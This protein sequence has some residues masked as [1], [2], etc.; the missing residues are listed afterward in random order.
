M[1]TWRQ[2]PGLLVWAVGAGALLAL[3][4]KVDLANLAMLLVMS[5]ALATLWLPA[6]LAAAAGTLAV[7]AFNW[8]FVPPRGSLMV[9]LRQHALLLLSMLLVNLLVVALMQRLRQQAEQAA[10]AG[11]RESRLRAWSDTLRDADEPLEQSATLLAELEALAGTPVALIALDHR[12]ATVPPARLT[13]GQPDADQ[14]AGLALCLGEGH[15]LGPGSGRF[16]AL[17]D[18]YL[19]LRGRGRTLGAVVLCGLGL[20]ATASDLHTQAQTLCDLFGQALQRTQDRAEARRAL[21]QAQLQSLRN[22]LLSAIAHDH[23]TP[24]A[25]ILGAASSLQQQGGRMDEP[26]RQRLLQRIVDE[27]DRLRR[28]TDNTLQLARLDAPGLQLSCDW[29]S[30]EDLVGAAL[31]R[32]RSHDPQRRLRARLDPG[33][34]LLWCDALLVSQALDNLIDNALKYSPADAPVELRVQ[35]RDDAV[36]LAV[37]DRGPGVPTAWRQQVFEPFWRGAV[38]AGADAASPARAGAGVGL[39]LCRAIARVHGGELRLRPRGHGGSSFELQL[40]RRPEPAVG[41]EAA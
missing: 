37:R 39:A 40:P 24:L 18:A 34:P 38:S 12:Q 36:T 32:A 8:R 10:A 2:A 25:A 5:S 16:E 19:P 26:Q 31:R 6:R 30:V 41:P 27:A 1:I 21:E 15:A 28:L 35:A 3:D 7:L 13:L 23:R 4:G 9:D 22:A 29:E 20:R 33:L 17:P 11:R 14:S